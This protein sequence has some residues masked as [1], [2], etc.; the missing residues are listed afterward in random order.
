[1]AAQDERTGELAGLTELSVDP[2]HPSWGHQELTVVARAHRGH[3][4][5]LLLKAAMLE[6]LLEREPQLEAIETYNPRTV[7]PTWYRLMTEDL[8][9]ASSVARFSLPGMP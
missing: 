4:L 7:F 1:M 5:G 9:P 2:D 3:R 6:L 8:P